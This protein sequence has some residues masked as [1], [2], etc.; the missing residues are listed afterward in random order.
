MMKTFTNMVIDQVQSAKKEVVKTT[1]KH[2]A[3]AQIANN[4]VDTQTEYT[5]KAAGAFIDA[6]TD[7]SRVLMSPA[8]YKV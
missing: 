5:K 4:F 8:T 1:V 6:W 3:L 7:L 2:D